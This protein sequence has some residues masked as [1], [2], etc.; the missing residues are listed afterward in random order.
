MSSSPA[1]TWRWIS[2]AWSVSVAQHR[3]GFDLDEE[4]GHG[5]AGNREEGVG[6]GLGVA[7]ELRDLAHHLHQRFGVGADDV[8]AQAHDVGGGRADRGEGILEVG[9]GLA[10]LEAV[11]VAADDVAILV[12]GGLP[13]DVR[14]AGARVLDGDVREAEAGG[15]EGEQK[16]GMDKFRADF[17]AKFN[18]DVQVYAP[19]VYDAVKVMANAMVTAGSA[20]PKVYLPALKS[21]SYNGVTGKIEFDEKGDI[22]NGALTLFTYKGDKR[23]QIAVVR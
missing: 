3:G 12:P 9:Q 19:Y 23:E 8:G 13:G 21:T 14:G 11:I 16:A 15:V 20:D 18:A 5:E 7:V 6:R 17:K 1:I 10:G 22:K 2:F 4:F